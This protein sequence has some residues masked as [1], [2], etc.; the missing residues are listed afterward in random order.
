[1]GCGVSS[2]KRESLRSDTVISTKSNEQIQAAVRRELLAPRL[3]ELLDKRPYLNQENHDLYHFLVDCREAIASIEGSEDEAHCVVDRLAMGLMADE[4]ATC[5]AFDRFDKTRTGFLQGEEVSYMLDYLGFP[6]NAEA[7]KMFMRSVDQEGDG[8]ISP[9]EFVSAV[10][11]LGGCRKL[12]QQRRKQ[13]EDRGSNGVDDADVSDV[14]EEDALRISLRTC[15]ILEEEQHLWQNVSGA[16]LS[17]AAGL[18]PC[19]QEAVRHIRNLARMNHNRAMPELLQRFQ[20]LGYECRDLWMCLAWIRELAPIIIHVDLYKVTE[21]LRR[22]THYRNQ[23][24]TARSSGILDFKVRR[25]W[26][27]SLFGGAY[28]D[29]TAFQ[30][31]KYGVL[32]VWNDPRGDLACE[33]YGDSYF[34]LKDVRLRC[35]F[36]SEDSGNLQADRLAVLDHYAHSLQEYSDDEL[37]MIVQL[38][39]DG[40]ARL[41]DSDA[42]NVV[43][44]KYKEAQIHGELDLSKHIERVVVNERHR[45]CAETCHAIQELAESKGWT[46]TWMNDMRK[47][48]QAKSQDYVQVSG[49]Q[50]KKAMTNFSEAI[51]AQENKPMLS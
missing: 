39:K 7:V 2:G 40:G 26:E 49:E 38:S 34:V 24:E 28:E 31:P 17:A 23:F 43:W 22:D 4:K 51:E 10:G 3:E 12:F 45:E 32:N 36:S 5:A 21:H 37:H 50:F 11:W 8:K 15:G 29:A 30:R 35:T 9:S 33:Q 1:M 25:K 42:V 18:K 46:L 47:E 6:H 19:Q 13:I 16:D 14:E 44:G 27:R 48:L 20:S 41:G